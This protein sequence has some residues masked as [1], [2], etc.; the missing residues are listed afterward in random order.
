MARNQEKAQS[1]LFRFRAA[2]MAELGLSGT[3][4]RPP[5][6]A[7]ALTLPEAERW[8]GQVVR[9][10]TRK[11]SR[12]HDILLT[13]TQIREVNDEI[14]KLGKEKWMWERRVQELGG[15][16]YTRQGRR[17]G[18]GDAFGGK[19]LFGN[20]GYRYYGRA[21]ELPD[22]KELFD[23]MAAEAESEEAA[24]QAS[25]KPKHD[26]AKL[27]A[28]YFGHIPPPEVL[29]QE[30]RLQLEGAAADDV[31]SDA[32]GEEDPVAA[33]LLGAHSAMNLAPILPTAQDVEAWMV[34]LRKRDLLARLEERT[35]V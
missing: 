8:R 3:D 32:E 33:L 21:R 24:A 30:Q 31:A 17:I 19:E 6:T 34:Q 35:A 12:I 26:R 14:N 15:P 10:I 23:K 1:M 29:A 9:E 16:D 2:Q 13:D 20:R 25:A 22:V 18:G 11:V 4:K 5:H 7:M 27:D 28:V